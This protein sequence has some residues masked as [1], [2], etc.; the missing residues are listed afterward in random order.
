MA[1]TGSTIVNAINAAKNIAANATGWATRVNTVFTALEQNLGSAAEKDAGT[2]GAGKVLEIGASGNIDYRVMPHATETQAG[3]MEIASGPEAV[4]GISRTVAVAPAGLK[5][6]ADNASWFKSS[7]PN[8]SESQRGMVELAT[9]LET[10]RGVDRTRAVTP[11][12]LLHSDY[13]VLAWGIVN[14][15]ATGTSGWQG[16][17]ISLIGKGGA[18]TYT[19][20]IATA[21][22]PLSWHW[23]CP[24]VSLLGTGSERRWHIRVEGRAAGSFDVDTTQENNVKADHDFTFVLLGVK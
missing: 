23:Y 16:R 10:E 17:G 13:R 19:V 20:Y 3:A 5:F 8:S 22:R 4:A 7:T 21:N 1:L 18:G 12:S 6:A 14:S 15:G 9:A 24:V 11:Y 2:T